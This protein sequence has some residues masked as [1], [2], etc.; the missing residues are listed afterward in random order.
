MLVQSSEEFCNKVFFYMENMHEVGGKSLPNFSI[1]LAC[2]AASNVRL[3]M[4]RNFIFS[5]STL[6]V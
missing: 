3:K 4:F 1:K 6:K 5:F 2:A